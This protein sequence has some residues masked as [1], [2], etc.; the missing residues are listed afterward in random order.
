MNL[1]ESAEQIAEMLATRWSALRGRLRA[2]G[3]TAKEAMQL[4]TVY[5]ASSSLD[6]TNTHYDGDL[7]GDE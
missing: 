3:F 2:K 6:L 5:V 1:D 7:E 4:L